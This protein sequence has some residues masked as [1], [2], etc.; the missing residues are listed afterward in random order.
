ML[1]S[2]SRFKQQNKEK[3]KI[4]QYIQDTIPIDKVYKDGIYSVRKCY[5]KTYIV[6]D[7]NYSDTSGEDKKE[8]Y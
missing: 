3:F 1:I 2:Q 5:S 4:P 6:S 8:F 7:I